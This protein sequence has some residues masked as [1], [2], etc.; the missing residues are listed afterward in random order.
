M[1]KVIMCLVY[2]AVDS[3]HSKRPGRIRQKNWFQLLGIFKTNLAQMSIGG[4]KRLIQNVVIVYNSK[5]LDL[6]LH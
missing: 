5:R 4:N 6:Y 2:S 1:S 3:C